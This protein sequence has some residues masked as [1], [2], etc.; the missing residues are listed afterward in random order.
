MI[1]VLPL[2]ERLFRGRKSSSIWYKVMNQ[3]FDWSSFRSRLLSISACKCRNLSVKSKGNSKD[4]LGASVILAFRVFVINTCLIGDWSRFFGCQKAKCYSI[5]SWVPNAAG[6][7]A[8][9]WVTKRTWSLQHS[10][11]FSRLGMLEAP[12][13]SWQQKEQKPWFT[14]ANPFLSLFCILLSKNEP[15]P[16]IVLHIP[17]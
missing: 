14:T 9:V 13:W 16:Y 11:L 5:V 2:S 3:V 4:L 10:F 7:L 12:W 15:F 17:N 1:N 8:A 6:R